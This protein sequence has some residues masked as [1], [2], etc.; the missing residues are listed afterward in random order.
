MEEVL[1]LSFIDILFTKIIILLIQVMINVKSRFHLVTQMF[2]GTS[3][4][5]FDHQC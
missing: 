2:E 1:V 5:D 3:H 4:V